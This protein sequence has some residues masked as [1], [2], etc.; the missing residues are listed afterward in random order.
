[1]RL[2]GL[3]KVYGPNPQQALD[4]LRR[5]TPRNEIHAN[6]GHTVAL[7][8]VSL[9]LP[10]GQVSVVMGLSGSGKSTLLRH[11]NRLVEPTT[12]QVW[13]GDTDVSALN[14]A[15]LQQLRRHRMAMVFQRYALFPHRTVLHNVA[16]A[17]GVRGA[18][19]VDAHRVARHWLERVGLAGQDNSWP[20][21]L[22][23]GMQ[24]RVGLARALASDAPVLLMDEAFSALDPLLRV[25][26]Q[27]LLLEL[28]RDLCKTV[29][30]ITH[31]LQEALRLGD[32][33]VILYDGSVVQQGD[34]ARIVLEPANEHVRRF[35]RDVDRG[36]ALK[37]GALAVPGP[38]VEGPTLSD[39]TSL[40]DAVHAL[41]VAGAVQANVSSDSGP[42]RGVVTLDQLLA[43]WAV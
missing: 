16:Y 24:Q 23:G 27:T 20:A 4:L 8:D 15:G 40:Q 43:C 5:G 35:V 7:H 9:N 34:P 2:Q 12:G 11:I 14:A 42:L 1:M 32:Q 17:A 29:V 39:Q 18:P 22:S 37:C 19:A 25:E 30:F 36:R 41:R 10:G 28:Q 33:V 21:T 38:A 26:M 31:D 6:T 13:C 3:S